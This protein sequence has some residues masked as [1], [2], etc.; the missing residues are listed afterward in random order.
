MAVG[1]WRD[2]ETKYWLPRLPHGTD[3]MTMTVDVDGG[4]GQIE[5]P[6]TV[7]HMFIA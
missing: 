3:R 4:K 7:R 6:G 2:H 1:G 5:R